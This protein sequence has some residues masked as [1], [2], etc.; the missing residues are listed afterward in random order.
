MF[1]NLF[2]LWTCPISLKLPEFLKGKISRTNFM[3]K[4]K[5]KIGNYLID[6]EDSHGEDTK[7]IITDFPNNFK[8]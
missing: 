4:K 6:S 2:N 7:I 1:C 3:K 5:W 8:S